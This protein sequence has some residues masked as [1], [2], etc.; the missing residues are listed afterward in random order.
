MLN[1]LIF[2]QAAMVKDTRRSGATQ[3][4]PAGWTAFIRGWA[5][6]A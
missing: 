4:T 2:A 3:A 5:R 1:H 6:N